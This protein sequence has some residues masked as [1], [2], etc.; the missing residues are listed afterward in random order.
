V[1]NGTGSFPRGYGE[2][3]ASFD[4]YGATVKTLGPEALWRMDP[5]TRPINVL[6]FLTGTMAGGE[7]EVIVV[8]AGARTSFK[9]RP[10]EDR[11]TIR[12]GL[13]ALRLA[14]APGYE[15]VDPD[16]MKSAIIQSK[17]EDAKLI[18]AAGGGDL[19]TAAARMR[20]TVSKYGL[21]RAAWG[22]RGLYQLELLKGFAEVRATAGT[23]VSAVGGVIGMIV[24]AA[25]GIHGSV[26]SKA[27]KDLAGKFNKYV[28][29]GVASA[30]PKIDAIKTASMK[31]VS[32]ARVAAPAVV[33]VAAPTIPTWVWWTGSLTAV[34]GALYLAAR[35]TK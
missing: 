35:A 21:E 18:A 13:A 3:D 1:W 34:G 14:G 6:G 25:M 30:Q 7:D 2:Y 15:N 23:I 16:S 5:A 11:A 29:E 28:A 12:G 26:S 4:A 33:P 8:A 20:T 24:S 10:T 9:N 19:K 27:A 31:Q 17:A 32:M 22:A